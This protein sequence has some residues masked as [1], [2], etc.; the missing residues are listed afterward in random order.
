V[1]ELDALFQRKHVDPAS[2]DQHGLTLL[3]MAAQNNQRKA[4]KLVLKRTDFA[5]TRLASSS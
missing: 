4:A 2:R 1:K 5:T 3:H